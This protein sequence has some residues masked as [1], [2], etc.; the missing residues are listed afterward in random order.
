MGPWKAAPCPGSQVGV[1]FYLFGGPTPSLGNHSAFLGPCLWQLPVAPPLQERG[2]R[3][4]VRP[5]RE[6]IDCCCPPRVH[7]SP[8]NWPARVWDPWRPSLPEA[9]GDC[10]CTDPPR[11]RLARDSVTCRLGCREPPLTSRFQ[12]VLTDRRARVP[13]GLG[14]AA[15]QTLVLKPEDQEGA[16]LQPLQGSRLHRDRHVLPLR[17]HGVRGVSTLLHIPGGRLPGTPPSGPASLDAARG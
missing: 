10:L 12:P 3:G 7:H 9:V 11:P 4:G 2:H 1:D 5:P 15:V 16:G 13:S 17:P 6:M 14:P 8:H